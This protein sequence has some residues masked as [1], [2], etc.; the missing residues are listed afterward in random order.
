MSYEL[1]FAVF[2]K[3]TGPWK[4]FFQ[5]IPHKAG[6]VQNNVEQC[7][8][9]NSVFTLFQVFGERLVISYSKNGCYEMHLSRAVITHHTDSILFLI[10]GVTFVELTKKYTLVTLNAKS[11]D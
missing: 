1:R 4:P 2:L 6:V 5:K 9:G 3:Q 8:E 10:T 11:T 7:Q